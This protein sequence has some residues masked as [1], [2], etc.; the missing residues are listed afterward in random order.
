MILWDKAEG[1]NIREKSSVSQ[2]EERVTRFRNHGSPRVAKGYA[3]QCS[4]SSLIWDR[5]LENFRQATLIFLWVTEEDT[6]TTRTF[7]PLCTIWLC[8]DELHSLSLTLTG[9]IHTGYFFIWFCHERKSLRIVPS[10]VKSWWW[11]CLLHYSRSL[12][13]FP[14]AC[15]TSPF[16]FR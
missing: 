4:F 11:I 16:T 13:S 15:N 2:Q 3:G 12:P 5:K 1:G 7:E 8:T 14:R 9:A 10:N 6:M